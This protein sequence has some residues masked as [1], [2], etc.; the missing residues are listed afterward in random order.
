MKNVFLMFFLIN[1]LSCKLSTENSLN[2]QGNTFDPFIR[3]GLHTIG[4]ENHIFIQVYIHVY[5]ECHYEL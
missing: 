5:Y 1:S 4:K 3:K 2:L